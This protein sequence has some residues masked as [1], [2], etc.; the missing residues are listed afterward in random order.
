MFKVSF[1]FNDSYILEFWVG[2]N[3]ILLIRVTYMSVKWAASMRVFK[4]EFSKTHHE[5]IRIRLG[6][7][8]T[9]LYERNMFEKELC[10]FY[11]LGIHKWLNNSRHHVHWLASI[12]DSLSQRKVQSGG[13]LENS[14]KWIRNWCF[15]CSLEDVI[16]S[17]KNSWVPH[18]KG[19]R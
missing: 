10:E 16:K 1:A 7:K 14:M 15:L 18:K 12:S 13:L 3:R 8:W 5:F 19:K 2:Y 6:P 17:G 11:F 4:A 9:Q